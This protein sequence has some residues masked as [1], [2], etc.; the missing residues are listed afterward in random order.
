[1]KRILTHA[2]LVLLSAGPILSQNQDNFSFLLAKARELKNNGQYDEAALTYRQALFL[3]KESVQPL[4]GLG[5]VAVAER[6]WKLAQTWFRQALA[7][8]P[9]N[10][11]ASDYFNNN[12]KLDKHLAEGESFL[13]SADLAAARKRFER[14]LAMNGQSL[15]ALKGLGKVA[16]ETE[17]WRK[18][19]DYFRRVQQ[20]APDDPDAAYYLDNPRLRSRLSLGDS[21]LALNKLKNAKSAYEGALLMDRRNLRALNG[22]G[23][24]YRRMRD[25]ETSKKWFVKALKV[26][27]RN[28][29]TNH[30]LLNGPNPEVEPVVAEAQQLQAERRFEDANKKYERAIRLYAGALPAFRGLGQI[31]LE[32]QDWGATKKWFKKLLEVQPLDLEA[33]YGLG[34]AYRE[35]GKTS[36]LIMKRKQ[37]GNSEDHLES[38]LAQDSTYRDVV[39]QRALLERWRGNWESA[40]TLGH[41]QLSLTPNH[42]RALVG[43]FKLHRL[44]FNNMGASE[45]A[46]WAQAS[47][48]E[49]VDFML[50]EKKRR[51]NKFAAA[52][53]AY[54]ALLAKTSRLQQPIYL[55]L[56]RSKVQQEDEA[57]AGRYFRRALANANSE[58]DL[59]FLFEDSKYIMT[60]PELN[61][62]RGLKLAS[63]K[64]AFF[65]QFWTRRNPV[66]AARV[67]MRV[68]EHYR[69]LVYAEQ[70]YWFDKVRSHANDADRA[71]AL[72]FPRIYGLNEEFNDKG[73]M[74][75]RHGEP[76]ETAIT[77]NQLVSNE[78]WH[79]Y[80]RA[81]RPKLIFHFMI[82]RTTAGNNWRLVPFLSDVAM[83]A[84]RL[85]WDP[86]MDQIFLTRSQSFESPFS[87][88]N[89]QAVR[90]SSQL[91]RLADK[92][93]EE[94]KFAMSRDFHTW[95]EKLSDLSL[96]FFISG[97]RGS[98]KKTSL[99]LYFAVPV[100]ELAGGK[101]REFRE[102][103]LE[104]G[105]GLYGLGWKPNDHAVDQTYLLPGDSSQVH[106]GY[107]MKKYAFS[108][109]PGKQ[110]LA[111]YTRD[112]KNQK[113]GTR[114]LDV[115]APDLS[116]GQFAMS[117][118]L[119]A[120]DVA[121]REIDSP[122]IKGD[123]SFIPNP[124][125][126]YRLSQPIFVF[127]EVYDLVRDQ[128][129]D[130]AF[131]IEIKMTQLKRK[132]SGLGRFLP[133]GKRKKSIALNERRQSKS[134]ESVEFTSF[135]VS[136]LQEGDYELAV[137]IT[138]ISSGESVTRTIGVVLAGK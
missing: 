134:T 47:P 121:P 130:C 63:H 125:K 87:G 74:Y 133:G 43:L 92:S 95:D 136:K 131:E 73:L 135:D 116:K 79:Y 90:Q 105:A 114:S 111:F 14:A 17:E 7:L 86:L 84:D 118:L 66:P 127:Y 19:G 33:K 67:N 124:S 98:G 85:G 132:K 8:E 50:A 16:F 24:I 44:V 83:I 59:A 91:N 30:F 37:F 80:S 3:Q 51:E 38:V 102:A 103:L 120:Y 2:V 112:L 15:A 82:E 69:R 46:A 109:A 41:R 70:N 5:E 68:L 45:F 31:A 48:G 117:D 28:K 32:Q 52:D 88:N 9:N 75:I 21:L 58:R 54:E 77:H 126:T 12:P 20:I 6:K 108:V 56:L 13:R 27:P 64:R 137:A 22:L 122:F 72:T 4:V 97:F 60:D 39:Y 104:H 40:L 71:G 1:M 23:R 65:A 25:W 57:Q 26:D 129:G 113:L 106:H 55:A 11:T 62:Y 93:R 107:F 138:D 110:R 100:E 99:E 10:S 128:R 36:S 53:S 78:S 101:S 49:W 29:D 94:V 119:L 76:N 96:P 35:T 89:G 123:V 42:S 34:V 81:D 18:F 61:F 115:E